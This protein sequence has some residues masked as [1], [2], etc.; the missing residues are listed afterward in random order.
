VTRRTASRWRLAAG[1][2]ILGAVLW[3][4]GTG[5]FVE[6]F[7]SLDARAVVL[8]VLLAVAATVAC[9]WRWRLVAQGLG[10]GLGLLPAVAGCYRSQFLNLTLPGGV[11]GDVHRGVTHGR[12][13]GDTGRGLRAVA[14]ERLA[15]QVVQA[16]VVVAILLLLPSPVRPPAWA[17]VGLLL[18]VALAVLAAR[19]ASSRR[20][21]A[22]VQGDLRSGLLGRRTWPG[23]VVASAVAV[24]CH[25]AT[26]VVAAR[27]VGV[28]VPPDRLVPLALL[29]LLAAGLP[30]NVAGWGPRE[31]AA[32]WTFGA[33]GLGVELGVATAVAYGTLVLVGNLPGAVVLAAG[34]R[35]RRG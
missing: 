35:A 34:R 31:G 2:A 16:L 32:G 28:T 8:G 10:V 18:L 15:G 9:A 25:V 14:W 5:P 17:V 11:L 4:T 21:L 24:G 30:V 12:D 23:V 19:G 13:A 26:Y 33:A 3:W 7:R 20:L 27:A 22:A 29:V 6:G 1:A